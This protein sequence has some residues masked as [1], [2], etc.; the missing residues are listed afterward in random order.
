MAPRSNAPET[1]PAEIIVVRFILV[2]HQD[3]EGT[4]RTIRGEHCSHGCMQVFVAHVVLSGEGLPT[5]CASGETNS[6]DHD[7]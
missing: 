7:R 2:F 5:G 6:Q 4:E 1:M 3:I